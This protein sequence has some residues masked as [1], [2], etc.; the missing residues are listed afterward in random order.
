M[1][2]AESKIKRILA[3]QLENEKGAEFAN[4]ILENAKSSKEWFMLL[5]DILDE[6]PTL[7]SNTKFWQD[8]LSI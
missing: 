1:K 7:T 3:E 4:A 6:V 5:L 2:Q 8:N